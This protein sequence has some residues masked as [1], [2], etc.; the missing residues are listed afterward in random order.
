MTVTRLQ[1]RNT[2]GAAKRDGGRDSVAG[3]GGGVGEELH[4]EVI[5]GRL[6]GSLTPQREKNACAGKGAGAPVGE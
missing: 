5:E 6:E 4:I 2:F 1:L 3:G